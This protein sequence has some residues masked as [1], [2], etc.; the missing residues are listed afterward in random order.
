MVSLLPE[1]MPLSFLQRRETERRGLSDKEIEGV[2][3][4]R[5]GDLVSCTEVTC[6]KALGK[7][8]PVS[9]LSFFLPEL[10]VT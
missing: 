4:V 9:S 3:E 5:V 7:L 10:T 1:L 6:R 8:L 2:N